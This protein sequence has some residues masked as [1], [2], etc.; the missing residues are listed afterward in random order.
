[1]IDRMA[2]NELI[3][4][5]EKLR[6]GE[7]EMQTLPSLASKRIADQGVEAILEVV[8]DDGLFQTLPIRPG[9]WT[10]EDLLAM[11]DPYFE[12]L[13]LF[14]RSDL[15]P[16][17]ESLTSRRVNGLFRVLLMS[18]IISAAILFVAS[19]FGFS[20]D[21]FMIG[22]GLFWI[23]PIVFGVFVVVLNAVGLLLSFSQ[24]LR[25]R[26]LRQDLTKK[27]Q[28][29]FERNPWPFQTKDD[30]ERIRL[31]FASSKNETTTTP[32]RT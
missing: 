21:N 29:E 14:L 16:A 5:I 32:D 15:D 12:R 30:L 23:P 1:M 3:E 2:R 18:A 4:H 28:Q 24:V 27:Y 19:H 20:I 9:R 10:K 17:P 31:A 25:V 8:T 22:F 26:I 13:V 11:W 6:R 7:F